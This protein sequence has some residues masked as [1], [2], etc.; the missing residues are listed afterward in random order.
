M[1]K[2]AVLERVYTALFW[3]LDMQ[4]TNRKNLSVR[5]L[6]KISSQAKHTEADTVV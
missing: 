2:I 3:S 4:K 5:T 6:A 1:A